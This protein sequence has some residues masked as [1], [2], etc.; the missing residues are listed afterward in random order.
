MPRPDRAPIQSS[1]KA[2]EAFDTIRS[3]KG[4]RAATKEAL[5]QNGNLPSLTRNRL[6]RSKHGV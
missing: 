1:Q 3:I 4:Y 6:P 2:K 5:K